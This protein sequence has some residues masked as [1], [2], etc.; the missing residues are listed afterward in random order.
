[1]QDP[2]TSGELLYTQERMQG[3]MA[4]VVSIGVELDL[5]SV[6]KQ[7]VES[8]RALLHAGYGALGVIGDEGGLSHFV[9][10]GIDP[11]LAARIGP[12]PT[13]HG[14][15]GL[16]IREPH[17]IR[18]PDLRRHPASYGFPAHHPPMRTFLGVP[19][20]VRGIVF[21]NLYLTEKENGELFTT[22]DE[23]LAVALA[24]AAGVA[25]EHAKLF[26][27]SLLRSR[28]LEACMDVAGTA[29]GSGK[30]GGEA[31][32]GMVATR[33]R[34]VS[35][36]VLVLIAVPS[37]DGG[38]SYISAAAGEGADAFRGGWLEL[39]AAVVR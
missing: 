39:D 32:P 13:G 5:A 11:E 12:L 19:I 38:P 35:D 23:D 8:A 2:P 21:G 20:R 33:A 3:L 24:T 4:A 25:I 9:T 34:D 18:L 27:D 36:S 10:V 7:I 15:L 26:D 1:M 22:E 14:V 30:D 6:L 17:P 16:L 29:M 31:G 28:W 37:D